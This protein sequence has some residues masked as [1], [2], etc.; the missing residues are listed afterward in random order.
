MHGCTSRKAGGFPV[1]DVSF[2]TT[3]ILRVSR[4][5]KGQDVTLQM[6]AGSACCFIIRLC[7]GL[8]FRWRAF[9]RNDINQRHGLCHSVW[10]SKLILR[11]IHH[12]SPLPPSMYC[13]LT[14]FTRPASS[15][16]GPKLLPNTKDPNAKQA[17]SLCPGYTASGVEHTADG[18]TAT[19]N[20]AGEAVSNTSSC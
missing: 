13:L 14:P 8:F 18:F 11:C 5:C 20:L 12:V 3:C 6:D 17:Q 10:R 9:D 15:D 2:R 1:R 4:P 19:L 16:E 7:S